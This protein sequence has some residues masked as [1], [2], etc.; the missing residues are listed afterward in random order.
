MDNQEEDEEDEEEENLKELVLDL[1]FLRDHFLPGA[2]G[3]VPLASYVK[4]YV[5]LNKFIKMLGLAYHFVAYDVKMKLATLQK[6]MAGANGQYYMDMKTMI[7]Y[8]TENDLIEHQKS[9]SGTEA[10]LMLHRGLEFAR[11]FMLELLKDE[12]SELGEVASRIY[13]STTGKYHPPLLRTPFSLV[14]KLLP[15]RSKI[16]RKVAK[17]NEEVEETLKKLLPEAISSVTETYNAC[18]KMFKDHDL[19]TFK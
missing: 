18:Q 5:E 14:L 13:L 3:E 11:D 7:K 19:L 2:E 6:K 9:M 15:C 1:V 8:E 10:L 4:G 17:E 12:E 16:R